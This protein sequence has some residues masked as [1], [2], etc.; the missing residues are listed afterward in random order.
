VGAKVDGEDA[1][2]GRRVSESLGWEFALLLK[3][4]R[5]LAAARLAKIGLHPGQDV[6]L[7][8]LWAEDGLTHSQLAARLRIEQPTVSKMLER[9][10]R[11]GLVRR[12]R[13]PRDGRVSRVFLTPDGQAVQPEVLACWADLDVRMT[14][15]LSDDQVIAL[16]EMLRLMRQDLGDA[17]PA[18]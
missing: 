16:R 9:L 2:A 17:A 14:R 15:R 7:S 12:E 5:G 8:A 10:E 18:S 6:F 13:D 3:A 4:H 1:H 11:A